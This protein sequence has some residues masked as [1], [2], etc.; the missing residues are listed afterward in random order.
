[1]VAIIGCESGYIHYLPNGKVLQGRV[2][3]PDTGVAQINV[4]AHGARIKEM[5]LDVNNIVDN[6]T[7][8]RMLYDEQGATPWV[9]RNLVAT[10]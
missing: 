1:M 6:L 5:G 2:H 4:K 8:A 3:S 10:R 7:F 9:C